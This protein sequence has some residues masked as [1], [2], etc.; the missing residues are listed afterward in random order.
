MSWHV[1]APLNLYA[2]YCI[3]FLSPKAMNTFRW[4]LFAYQVSSTF[5]DFTFSMGL[6]P[7]VIPA[8]TFGYSLLFPL[9]AYAIGGSTIIISLSLQLVWMQ[10]AFNFAF[11]IFS[12]YG[13]AASICL[14]FCNEPYRNNTK[15][16]FCCLKARKTKDLT[17]IIKVSDR[18]AVIS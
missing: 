4:H 8:M 10:E 13:L 14:I 3:V 2:F 9:T 16:L 1:Q 7:V 17:N 15:R 6:T 5:L 18:S 11:F 12:N